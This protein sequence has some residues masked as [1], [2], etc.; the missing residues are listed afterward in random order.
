MIFWHMDT[1]FRRDSVNALLDPVISQIG[2]YVVL[3]GQSCLQTCMTGEGCRMDIRLAGR[4]ISVI[5]STRPPRLYQPVYP[6]LM[7]Y[8]N[9]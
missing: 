5:A 4:D 9:M 6:F 3:L 2:L 8:R 7:K 1:A